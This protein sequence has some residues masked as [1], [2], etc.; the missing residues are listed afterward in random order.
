MKKI[1]ITGSSGFLGK[2]LYEYLKKDNIIYTLNRNKGNYKINLENEIPSFNVCFDLVIHCAGK[3]HIYDD[4]KNSHYKTNVI[5]SNNLLN[6]FKNNHLP[7]QIIYI[8]SVSV[9]GLNEGILIDES[10]N[11]LAKDKYGLSKIEAEAVITNWCIN[12]KVCYTILRLP[13]IAGPKPPGNLGS[14]INFINKG[15]YFNIDNGKAKKSIVLGKDV[16]IHISK[17]I[18]KRGIYN[19]TDGYHPSFYELSSYI[20][21]TLNKNKIYN[22]SKSFSTILAK[23][24]NIFGKKFPFNERK[25]FQMTKSLTFSDNKARKDFEWNPTCV[26]GNFL[27]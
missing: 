17:M 12:H 27:N 4:K 15:L 7:K 10:H 1:L 3:A 13:L 26:I 19:L 14:M 24:G 21:Y 2:I 20:G 9:Y 18:G 25:L 5:G 8:S 22:L 6:G 11:L 16:A 23:I